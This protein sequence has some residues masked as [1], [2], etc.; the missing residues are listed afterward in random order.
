MR[1]PFFVAAHRNQIFK[2]ETALWQSLVEISLWVSLGMN[3]TI[4]AIANL[5]LR[6][7]LKR[8][9]M[10]THAGLEIIKRNAAGPGPV[11]TGEE[12]L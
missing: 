2:T 7:P 3:H 1:L 10:S 6:P 4:L 12:V 8:D 9:N 11:Q 5:L